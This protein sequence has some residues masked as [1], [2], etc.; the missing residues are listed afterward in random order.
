MAEQPDY[1]QGET[2][3]LTAHAA[4]NER[5]L[6]NWVKITILGI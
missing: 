2:K 3:L 5:C 1:L 6:G 4:Y